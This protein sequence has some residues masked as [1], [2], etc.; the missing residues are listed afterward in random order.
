MTEPHV[1]IIVPFL[2]AEKYLLA[3][4][5]SVFAQT[6]RNWQLILVDDGSTD[7]STNMAKE[8]SRQHTPKVCYL[9]HPKHYNKGTSASRNLGLQ[10]AKGKL[11]ICLDADDVWMPNMLEHHVD[12][13]QRNSQLAMTYGPAKWWYSWSGNKED[14]SRDYVQSLRVKL[15]SVIYPPSLVELFLKHEEAVPSPSGVLIRRNILL[16]IGR[17]E[18]MFIGMYDDQALYVKI[19]LLFP[20][21]V[22]SD[23]LYYY[24]Q[25]EGSLCAQSLRNM[26][27]YYA[28]RNIFLHWLMSYLKQCD[29]HFEALRK[30]AGYELLS[31]PTYTT[32]N[33]TANLRCNMVQKVHRILSASVGF[34]YREG[35]WFMF[36]VLAVWV[37]KQTVKKLRRIISAIFK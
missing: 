11:V 19:G 16:Q 9:E 14:K 4:V 1:S 13:L 26:R 3:T 36:R 20:V 7:S 6:F 30:I 18:D 31:L 24:R 32:T 33:S 28:A 25:H 29:G 12:T 8:L 15:D 27:Q 22:T 37:A 10:H 23:C 35:V 34:A 17:W 2:N 21:Y 5:N